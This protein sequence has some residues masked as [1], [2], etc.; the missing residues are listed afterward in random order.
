MA[1]RAVV[2]LNRAEIVD[3]NFR[4]YVAGLPARRRPSREESV[5]EGSGLRVG[6]FLELFDS[7]MVSRQLDL[8]ARRLRP[9]DKVFYTIGSSGHEGNAV[10]GRLSRP[11]DPAF[12]HYRSGAFMA[13]RYRY[14]PELDFIRDTTLALAASRTDPVAGGRHKAWGSQRLWVPPQT[15]TIASHLPKAVG[16]ALALELFRGAGRVLP[17]DSIVLCSFGDAS[18]DHSTL[19]GAIN[20]VQWAVYQHLPAPI[21]FICEDNGWGISVRTPPGWI[22]KNFDG[23]QGL[24]YVAADGTDLCAAWEATREAIDLC[25]KSRRAV[26]LH[27]RMTR[28]L[29]HAGTDFEVEYR[30]EAELQAAER[31]DPLLRSAKIAAESGALTPRQILKKYDA[32][33]LACEK[34]G[35]EAAGAPRLASARQ[36]MG[37]L[38]ESDPT[39]VAAEA[40][41]MPKGTRPGEER[42]A[43]L[44]VQL[45]RALG[46]ALEKYPQAVIFG[47]DVAQK[48]G[49]YTVTRGLFKTWSG[50]RVFNT[51]LDEQ[52]ILGLAQGCA[53]GGL[54]PIAEIQYLAYLHH[55][56]DQLR[57][58]ACSLQFFSAGQF[59]NPMV[60]RV[61]GLAYQKG[62]GGHFHNDN[63]LAALR[64]IPGLVVA[65]PARA[66]DAV[67]MLRSC[68][69]LAQVDGRVVIFLE[70]IALYMRKDLYEPGDGRWQFAYPAGGEI[71]APGQPRVYHAQA[72]DLLILTFG[73]GVPMSLCAAQALKAK[74][75]M[76]AC[77]VDLR[78][79]QPLNRKWIAQQA[80]GFS[81]VLV[82]DEGRRS[83]GISE[84]VI[85][86]IVED[87]PS[88]PAVA[89]V[90]GADTY[91][92]LGPAA[93]TVLPSVREVIDRA[94]KLV[95]S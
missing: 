1:G 36:V 61:A 24:I 58:E 22:E 87:A 15:S 79:L 28:L 39:R 54:L 38:L 29:G 77:V 43:H 14:A 53:L 13:E 20:A 90:T 72:K 60:I 93:E 91:I 81:H 40:R 51:L 85:T 42:P 7:Q 6:D 30:Q 64:D 47:E 2:N 82:V 19:L 95:A 71:V 46:E 86:L 17:A 62:F 78:W 80:A 63:A 37:P 5:R 49:V 75:G 76:D 33:G 25:R 70:P 35:Q 26:F 67:A 11:T 66:D 18:A 89:R 16:M 4:D 34:A 83:G 3:A 94:L 56:L 68:L 74:H 50:R 23:R 57:G 45:N 55:A 92:P 59:R 32:I 44:A 41:R 52:T 9:Q 73:N 12:L 48:G 84:A 69:A 8:L 88:P 65:C 27:L 21:V 31:R 10:V